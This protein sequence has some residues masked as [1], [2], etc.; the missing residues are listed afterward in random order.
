MAT[1]RVSLMMRRMFELHNELRR[2]H[3]LGP[4]SSQPSLRQAATLHALDL[5]V[6]DLFSHTGSDG[7]GP[8]S[9]IK[10]AG[11]LWATFAEN[12]AWGVKQRGNPEAIFEMWMKSAPHKANILHRDVLDVGFGCASGEYKNRTSARVWVADFGRQQ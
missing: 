3:G 5:Q 8:G 6:H 10:R 11:Y 12:I 7:S 4:L 2:E 1:D 9:R